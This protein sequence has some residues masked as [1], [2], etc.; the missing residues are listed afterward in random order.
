MKET[1]L[2]IYA[3]GFIVRLE[4]K[5]IEVEIDD[6]SGISVM[7]FSTTIGDSS[8]PACSHLNIKNKIRQTTI[9]L[10]VESLESIAEGYAYYKKMKSTKT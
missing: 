9:N 8:S 7:N 3:N 2:E 10:S 1:S 6:K 4:N 5:R